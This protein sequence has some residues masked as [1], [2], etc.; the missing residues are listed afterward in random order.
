MISAP[1]FHGP[2]PSPV[3]NAGP[4]SKS[5]TPRADSRGDGPSYI[6]APPI[7]VTGKKASESKFAIRMTLSALRVEVRRACR[8][9]SFNPRK[10]FQYGDNQVPLAMEDVLESHISDSVLEAYSLRELAES[11]T[12]AVEEHL[13]VCDCC[14]ARLEAIE[15]LNFIHFT[16]DGPIYSR[17]TRLTTGKVV[18]RHW[19]RELEGGAVFRS[20]SGA[21][22]YLIQSFSQ[23]FPEHTCTV[24]VAGPTSRGNRNRIGTGVGKCTQRGPDSG[25]AGQGEHPPVLRRKL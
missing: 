15:P 1:R 24:S 4:K 10:A 3:P 20:V 11:R 19:G 16:E 21:R 22:K 13:L 6:P 23:M 5:A 14:R 2:N 25:K 12:A 18:A 8:H 17:A 9:G 7:D